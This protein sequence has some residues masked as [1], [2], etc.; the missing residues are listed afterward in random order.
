MV[1]KMIVKKKA[2]VKNMVHKSAK[3]GDFFKMSKFFV[4]S[5]PLVKS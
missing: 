2:M 1:E 5:V 3:F 4:F